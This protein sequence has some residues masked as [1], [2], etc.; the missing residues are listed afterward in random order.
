MNKNKKAC[1]AGSAAGQAERERHSAN[2][3]PQNNCI[4]WHGPI[5]RLLMEGQENGLQEYNTYWTVEKKDEG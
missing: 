5:S 3:D 2:G 1:P 4:I